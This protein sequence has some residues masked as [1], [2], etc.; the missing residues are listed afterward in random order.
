MVPSVYNAG[1]FSAREKS[2]SIKQE[3]F[4]MPN[5]LLPWS[6]DRYLIY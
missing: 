5:E 4:P 6:N 3:A 1:I 2:F